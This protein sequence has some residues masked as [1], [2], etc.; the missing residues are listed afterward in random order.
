MKSLQFA[1]ASI[2]DANTNYQFGASSSSDPIGN[3]QASML[4]GRK[5]RAK[6]LIAL[7]SSFRQR[8][9]AAVARYRQH[10]EYRQQVNQVLNLSDRMLSDIGLERGDLASLR[11]GLVTL[12]QLGQKRSSSHRLASQEIQPKVDK[13]T[14]ARLAANQDRFAQVNCA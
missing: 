9:A 4:E 7:L 3:Y 1:I 14:Q 8:L 10:A 6:S 2:V 5:I 11:A 13:E 12:E